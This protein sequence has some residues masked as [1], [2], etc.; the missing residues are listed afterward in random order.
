M[1]ATLRE[2]IRFVFLLSCSTLTSFQVVGATGGAVVGATNTVLDA[3]SELLTAAVAH[4]PGISTTLQTFVHSGFWN[5]YSAV[6]EF[7]HIKLRETL[8]ENP[9]QVFFT[10]HSLGGA[11]ATFAALDFSIH[12]L[13]RINKYIRHRKLGFVLPSPLLLLLTLSR[14][15]SSSFSETIEKLPKHHCGDV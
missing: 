13:D 8:S 12:S 14:R 15:Q 2:V 7:I 4:T 6:R 5:S 11:L 3:T 1:T 9:S 10:G